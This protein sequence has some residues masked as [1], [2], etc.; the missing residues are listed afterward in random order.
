MDTRGNTAG[1]KA[2]GVNDKIKEGP[3][4]QQ[5]E[6]LESCARRK[7]VTNQKQQLQ[8]CPSETDH[9]IKCINKHPLFFQS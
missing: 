1:Q 5:F 3:C 4:A 2:D 8:S 6:W 7:K 9:L